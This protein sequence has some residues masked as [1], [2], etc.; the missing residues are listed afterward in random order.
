MIE[1]VKLYVNRFKDNM[2]HGKGQ[3]LY[4]DGTFYEGDFLF[5]K[6]HGLCVK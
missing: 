2:K 5:D 6:R 1:E 4:E 3:Q